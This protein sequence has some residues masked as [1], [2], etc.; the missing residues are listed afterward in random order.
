[1]NS[2][3]KSPCGS[4]YVTE[5]HRTIEPVLFLLRKRGEDYDSYYATAF[6]V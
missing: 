6:P 1:M 4:L 2:K 5:K 3:N